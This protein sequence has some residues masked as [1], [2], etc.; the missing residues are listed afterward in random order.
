MAQYLPLPDGSSVTV[1]E[2][3]SPQQAWARAQKMYPEAFQAAQQPKPEPTVG[4]QVK[5]F[6]KGVLPGGIG[7]L[8]SAAV[9]AS[10]LLPEDYEKQARAGI[11]SLAGAAKKP[12]EAAPGYED[13][14][15]RKFGEA[16]GSIIP[17]LAIGPLGAA[18]RLTAAGL[19]MGMGA[20][21]A[22][23]R[24]EQ[25]GAT[26]EQRS[27]ATGLGSVVGISEMFAPARILGRVGEP[28]KNGIAAQLKRIALAGG[29]EA[30]QEAAS[31]AAQNLIAKGIYKPE[32]A[33]IEQ[34]GES[35]AYGGAVGALAQGLMDMALGRR[36]K[37][38]TGAPD[39]IA[40]A[41]AEANAQREELMRKRQDP[42]YAQEIEAKYNDLEQQRLDLESQIKKG[43]KGEPLS[44]VDQESNKLIRKQLSELSKQLGPTAAEYAKVKP[45]LAKEAEAQRLGKLAPE[46]VMMDYLG[47][48]MQEPGTAKP[49]AMRT[50]V[51][52]FG[53]ILEE[54]VE[55]APTVSE[56]AKYAYE[57][58]QSA[59]E[60]GQFMTDD[61]IG[62]L[63]RDP[64]KAA[65][66]AKNRTPLPG[67]DKREAAVVYDGLKLQLKERER[68]RAA[69]T[70]SVM[71]ERASLLKA[72]VL[73][74]EE[75]KYGEI[76][77]FAKESRELAAEDMRHLDD[78]FVSALVTGQPVVDV[79]PDI[80]VTREAPRLRERIEQLMAQA[81]QAD[82]DYR[83][84]RAA[85]ERPAAAEAFDRARTAIKQLQAMEESGGAYAKA[86]IGARRAQ[87]EAM[88][89]IEDVTDQLRS[90]Q[91]LGGENKAMASSTEQSLSNEAARQRAAYITNALQEAALHRRAQGL[92]ALTHDEAIKASSKMYDTF[93]DWVERAKVRSEPAKYEEKIVQPAQMRGTR[94][95]KP[96]VTERVEVA[97]ATQA[98]SPAEI[99]HFQE[100]LQAVRSQ[101][102]E[103]PQTKVQTESPLLR[104]Q[105][106]PSEAAK[107][108]EA[109]G[110]TATTLGGELRRRTEYVRDKMARM[111]LTPQNLGKSWLGTRNALNAAADVMDAGDATR[112]LLDAVEPVVDAVLNRRNVTPADLQAIKD[113]MAA[114]RPTA[115]EQK[116]EGQKSL[117]PET[118]EDLGYIRMTPAN[119]TKSPRIRPVWEALDR[120]RAAA[121]AEADRQ[122][123]TKQRLQTGATAI[124]RIKDA[125]DVI[126]KD[127]QFFMKNTSRYTPT[128]LSKAL[129]PVI[130]VGA[131]P[132]E[133]ALIDKYVRRPGNLTPEEKA[134]V[135][136]ILYTYRTERRTEYQTRLNEAFQM[137]SKGEQIEALDNQLYS[138]MA[139]VNKAQRAAAE[140]LSK[141]IGVYKKA[142]KDIQDT[143]RASAAITPAQ[144]AVLDQ[145]KQVRKARGD[146]QQAVERGI[147][148]AY[149]EM[150]Q[151]LAELLDPEI[152]ATEKAVAEARKILVKEKAE[153][154]RIKKRIQDAPLVM[155][156]KNRTQLATYQQ[157]Q[158][159]EKA[160][161]IEDL[162]KRLK[163][164]EEHLHNIYQAR[165]DELDSA[166]AVAM[167][168]A[169]KQVKEERNY[170]EIMEGQLA[171]LRGDNI[172]EKPNLYPFSA[173]RIQ[174]N[175]DA[176]KDVVKTAEKRVEDIKE[177]VKTD[178]EKVQEFIQKNKL[179]G[180]RRKG[181]VVEPILTEEQ[182][183]AEKLRKE[184]E[185]QYNQ[186]TESE[187]AAA[188]KQLQLDSIDEEVGA[189]IAELGAYENLPN[190]PN[191][192]KAL[193]E[194]ENTRPQLLT[195]AVAKAGILQNIESLEAQRDTIEAGRP[196]RKPRAA[197]A[198]TTAVQSAQMPFRT[199]DLSARAEQEFQQM[200]RAEQREANLA[201]QQARGKKAPIVA[202]P[203]PGR[204]KKPSVKN[205]SYW[206][207]EDLEFSKG[208][209][210]KKGE[211]LTAKQLQKELDKAIGGQGITQSRVQVFDS[212]ADFYEKDGNR[213]YDY[214]DIPADAKA[215]V[216]PATG[217]AFMFANRIG[218]G[219]GLG[220]LLH[221]VGVHLGFRNLFNKAQYDSLVAAV[222]N[223]AKKNDGS[224]ESRVAKA[225]MER[226]KAAKT[227]AEQYDDELLAY[228]VEEAIK[229]GV[230]PS[231]LSNGS[232]IR[233]WLTTV[234][235]LLKKALGRFGINPD[236]MTAG[237]LVNLAYG[238]A[239]LEV[240]GTWHGSDAVF[241]A[242]DT[243][244]AGAGEGA[245]DRRFDADNSLG[246]GPY[247]TPD[248][249]YG[250]YYQHAVPMG[251]AANETG[252]GN[253]TYQDY[254]DMDALFATKSNDELSVAE[255]QNK[256]ESIL[257]TRYVSSVSAGGDLDPTKNGAVLYTLENFKVMRDPRVVK[258]LATLSA[259][260]IK[261]FEKRPDK[262][263]LYRTLDDI[264]REKVFYI[265]SNATLGDRPKLDAVREKYGR[266][267]LTRKDGTKKDIG[268]E[269]GEYSLNTMFSGMVSKHGID[270]TIKLLKNAGI[271]AIERKNDR[272][273][274]ERAYIDQAPEILAMN[275]QPIGPA[276]GLL[277]SKAPTYVNDEWAAA[278]QTIDKFVAKNKSWLDKVKA[279]TT[280][281]AFET[282]LV[283]RFA[284]Y[285]RLRKYMDEHKGTQMMYYMR[286]YDQRMNMVSQAV[287][288]GAPQFVEKTRPDGNKEYIIEAKEGPSIKNVVQI[289][290]AAQPMVGNGDAVNRAFTMYMAAIRADNKG[291]DSLNFGKDVTPEML[292][293][294]QDLVK[295][296][297]GLEKIFNDAR[298]EYNAYNRN[299]VQFVADS[300][301]ISQELADTLLEENDYIP[302]YRERNGVAE[303]VIGSEA[304][305]RI[306]STK[307][308]PYLHELLG[309]D[310][311]ILDFMTSSVQNTNMLLDMGLRN[312]A[313]KNAVFELLDLGAAKFVKK[314]E[315]TNVVQFKDGGETKYAVLSTE[316]VRIGNKE[317]DTGVPA[318]IL[319]KGM[320]GIPTQMPLLV[321]AM[322]VPA[323]LLRKSV[324][325]SPLY[326]ARQL[327]RDSLAAPLL[328]GANFT[329]V[330]GALRQIGKPTKDILERRG[331]TGGQQFTGSAQ[332]ISK[333]LRDI[334]D[335]KPGWMEAL[336]KFEAMGME[337][338]AL[339]RRAQYNSYI[340]QGM[341]EMEAT[342]MSLESMN[343]NKRGASPSVHWANALIPFFNAQIQGLNVLYKAM[344]GKMPFNDKLR[345]REKLLQR[346]SMM[347]VASI[348][349]A[350]AMQDDEAY[351]NAT[352]DQKYANWF[353][354]LPGM[355]EPIRVPIPFE[356]GYIFKAL[357]EALVNTMST[358][359]GGE[360]A[361]QALR[362]IV[363]QTIP[364]GSNY[365][366]PQAL[367]PAIEAGL[368]KSFYTG[369]DILSQREANLLPEEQFRAN[370]TDVA[371]LLG[372]LG[373]SPI[374]FENLVR[375]YTGTM[376]IAFLQALS[377]GVP[378]GESPEQATRRLSEYPVIGGAWQ[379]NDAGGIANSAYERMN[380]VKKL[381]NTINKMVEEGRTADA[382]A[383][384]TKRSNEYM[385]AELGD[386]FRSNM[387]ELTKA[388]RAIQASSMTAQQKREQ[389]DEI[390]K[391][392]T[393]LAKTTLEMADKTI[394][395]NSQP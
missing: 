228:S 3:E 52:E 145:E 171:N 187:R 310:Q 212:L 370:T 17:F 376:G 131:T 263:N 122:V 226:V 138:H 66:I 35:A 63:M 241:T 216:D 219:E 185:N 391:L 231:A 154:D 242:F 142:L 128:E 11:T 146:Y 6:F 225:A 120:A 368:G 372:K 71:E 289:L 55:K 28:V 69:E 214:P 379:P 174:A 351:Q 56:L 278:G 199:G 53:R 183:R 159:E 30:A 266:V 373:I 359:R 42:A 362:Q 181:G 110:E 349:Y 344:S 191:T 240:R 160:S 249:E 308:Q 386:A 361:L 395:L 332:D 125:M 252:Y 153:L 314:A 85:R 250:E 62:Y 41:R 16:A 377:L 327:F 78:T 284:G 207:P 108:A 193:I 24:A 111:Q 384:M 261:G 246:V 94:I 72:P 334:S 378:K 109:R 99:R 147:A 220:V 234:L 39:E 390:R 346:G 106:A 158:Y 276:K 151:T 25:E 13:T 233:N 19:G 65:E 265:N 291:F 95:V 178:N 382:M 88:A 79:S 352:P 47:I 208:T 61:Y 323:Q 21:E 2:G 388:E 294:T 298:D 320:E 49:P 157:F 202:T 67:L 43:K 80:Q 273:Y 33:I 328:S 302:F 243:D 194:D 141:R 257:L 50:V 155:V 93:N 132:E 318:D 8:E 112:D 96:A 180:I 126:E 175:I 167:A 130:E 100:R 140:A 83:T 354:R 186:M 107:V 331:I 366:I 105:F 274:I 367:K 271:E 215:F 150:N 285:E 277:F 92:P 295:A 204:G 192:L 364:G 200:S 75:Q 259:D 336:G 315:G 322:A 102:F 14:V 81:D 149:A 203:G 189:L 254:R 123:L 303:L 381:E 20:G 222:K 116:E 209:R 311:P 84:A 165:H 297:P 232:P 312:M 229:A 68:Q 269:N 10:A 54:P 340:E 210:P 7:A 206:F 57:Q 97:P 375:G 304:P 87:F 73:P 127:T 59:R 393:A 345:I 309:G 319:I 258:A 1:R 32:Q 129:V 15:G 74:D 348:A 152:A 363:L 190:D 163:E 38:A 300:G 89:K 168:M 104:Q 343:F 26:A 292:K 365:G 353:V 170:L 51:D 342:L 316:K 118:E 101:L 176:Q 227:S 330:I 48:K 369:R 380:E 143:L 245:Y 262:G 148:K 237:D 23:T 211:G 347:A 133:N 196:S 60:S 293:E 235:N 18:G 268:L 188:V 394:R 113:S 169:D 173:Q 236:N 239:Q 244:Y 260:K 213:M 389:L 36:A 313:T 5:E 64:A 29:E 201:A 275:L 172:L 162:E 218:K 288:R 46:D 307:E 4:G 198:P 256:Y 9:G 22:R 91:T 223:W 290:K 90:A 114:A 164:E 40:Q 12:F 306:G 166:Q 121:K 156:A 296:T 326:M 279:N 247:T 286:M 34:V 86:F 383:L 339:T 115:I 27:L 358:E 76:M 335:G 31:Q 37:G 179:P 356:I 325:L 70:K 253:K 341:S 360:E 281:L 119:F 195:Q 272:K 144:R 230:N 117:F 299:L 301:A 280:G 338:D 134:K 224:I 44:S 221:E 255:L 287:G 392:K 371:K 355:D 177:R 251:K 350:L 137:L 385:Q 136:K 98:I 282:Q 58:I 184:A 321:R 329:P 135:D 264:P 270:K 317:F 82:R 324:T 103:R 305:I 283:D 45:L 357:P 267:L 77:D 238:A 161:I 124:E 205:D 248:K 139:G 387:Q 374:V 217:Q 197:T 337:A 333:I 182:E